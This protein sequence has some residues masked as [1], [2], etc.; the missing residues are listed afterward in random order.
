MYCN[1]H[2]LNFHNRVLILFE[3][4]FRKHL[5]LV[6]FRKLK[7]IRLKG[8]VSRVGGWDAPMGQ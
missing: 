4:I 1:V 7:N 5:F 6:T 8:T 2:F 3:M